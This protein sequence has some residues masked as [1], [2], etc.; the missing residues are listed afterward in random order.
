MTDKTIDQNLY[1]RQLGTFGIEAQGKLIKMKVF[2]YGL[3]GL[4]IETAKN[5]I[6]AG[7]NTVILHDDGIV[8]ARDLGSNFYLNEAD[9]GKRTRAESSLEQLKD[10]NMYVNVSIHSGE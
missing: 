9:V 7:P 5:L 8:E 2:I 1:S 3:R 6:L 4:G 10:L